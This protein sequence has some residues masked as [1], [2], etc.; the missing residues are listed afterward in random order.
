[1]ATLRVALKQSVI[2]QEIRNVLWFAGGFATHANAQAIIDYVRAAYLD[3]TLKLADH[4]VD[5]WS[6]Y[7]ADVKDV[8]DP[9]N[10]T[11]P[12]TFT[13]GPLAGGDTGNQLLP[14]MNCMLLQFTAPTAKP[15][16]KRVYIAGW[17][18]ARH[19]DNGWGT[20][21]LTAASN[22]AN[23]LLDIPNA[24]DP[25]VTL[26]VTRISRP[27]GVLVGSNILDGFSISPYARTQRR[28]TPG[29]GI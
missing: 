29:R 21:A 18:D 10:P 16:R 20:N 17:G 25:G 23:Y 24:L 7:G 28:R 27:G 8:T 19:A 6:L 14:L 15:N 13:A 4:L 22:W 9:A 26:T 5:N 12:Y 11:I 1:M 3:G 2:N